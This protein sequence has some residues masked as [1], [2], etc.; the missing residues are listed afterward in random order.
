MSENNR[1]RILRGMLKLSQQELARELGRKQGSVSDIERGRNKVD[2]IVELLR[3]RFNVNPVWLK[4]GTGEVFIR[5]IPDVEDR[6]SGVPYFNVAMSD[7]EKTSLN[8]F[9]EDP[10]YYVNFRPFNDCTAYLPVYGDSMYPRYANGDLIA[11]KEVPNT[12][13][14][15]WGEAYLVITNSSSNAMTTLKLLF[16]HPDNSKIILRAS[17]PNFRGDTIIERKSISA[18][19]IVK[20]KVTRTHI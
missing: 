13:V 4:E 14:I 15:L 16:E 7:I 17:N 9:N 10:E 1:L 11:V 20:G 6:S 2:G 5:K 8:E 3:L 19:Y 18:L 12:D